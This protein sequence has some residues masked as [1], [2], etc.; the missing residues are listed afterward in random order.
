M[1]QMQHVAVQPVT[2]ATFDRQVTGARGNV[3]VEFTADWCPPCR[4][5]APVLEAFA[6]EQAGKLT[7]LAYDV[8]N[9]TTITTR[10][11]VLGFPTLILFRDGEP[12]KQLIGARTKA[13][14]LRELGPHLA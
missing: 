8:A 13:S 12:V 3:L 9:D 1:A 10:Y 4:V 11:G 7:V 5:L 14:L 2:E 6:R